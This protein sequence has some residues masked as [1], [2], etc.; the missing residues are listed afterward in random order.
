M[1]C[2]REE[3]SRQ[4]DKGS[5]RLKENRAFKNDW[6]ET[7]LALIFG[8]TSCDSMAPSASQVLVEGGHAEV[9][10]VSTLA[11]GAGHGGKGHVDGLVG[12]GV[13]LDLPKTHDM[14][15]SSL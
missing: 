3:E 8:G 2:R 12:V 7:D 1:R 14:R 10:D 13:N 4:N 11:L 15:G 9:A 5:W 6:G